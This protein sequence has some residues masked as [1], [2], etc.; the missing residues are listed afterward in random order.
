MICRPA[1]L[2]LQRFIGR[3]RDAGGEIVQEFPPA[4]VPIL[5]GRMMFAVD[6]FVAA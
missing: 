3:L 5:R 2:N 1:M 6:R 4:C